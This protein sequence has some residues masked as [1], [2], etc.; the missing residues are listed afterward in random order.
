MEDSTP[1]G[2][3]V[4]EI[5]RESGN[6]DPDHQS[7]GEPRPHLG[8]IIPPT[9]LGGAGGTATGTGMGIPMIPIDTDRPKDE[10]TSS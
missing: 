4:E 1:L 7:S 10:D 6:L 2:K 8:V 9:G 5:E 3:S